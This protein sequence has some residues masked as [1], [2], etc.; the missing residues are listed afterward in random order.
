VLKKRDYVIFDESNTEIRLTLWGEK[1]EESPPDERA[2]IAVKSVKVG[3]FGGRTL[4]ATSGTSVRLNPDI[5][6]ARALYD[7]VSQFG[8][9][10][11]VSANLSSGGD[12]RAAEP[13]ERRKKIEAI[14]E[15]AM[16]LQEA[17]DNITIKATLN[18]I[19]HD[20]EPWYT[21]CP[22]P[23]G[24]NKKVTQGMGNQWHCEKCNQDYPNTVRRYIL[25]V[26]ATDCSGQSWLS[27]FN[28]TAM[29]VM[30]GYTA[31]SLYEMKERGE[32]QQFEQICQDALWRTYVM[33]VRIKQEIVK[34]E[35]RMKCTVVGLDEMDL[36]SECQ[37]M[38]DA[39][40]K[41]R[42]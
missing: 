9:E 2:I 42:D 25:S 27:L 26:T 19:K 24:C 3:D 37:Q 40:M 5:P 23:S 41:Y 22:N 34:D 16:G 8:G 29:K 35:P 21:S 39:I 38:H 1:A 7:W 33:R 30:G 32:D 13:L 15:E 10:M 17:A 6:E 18:Y 11:P 12:G 31:D 14:R 36:V 4:G 20:T 28:D